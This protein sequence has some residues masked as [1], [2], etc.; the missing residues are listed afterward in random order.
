VG[1]VIALAPPDLAGILDPLDLPGRL[2][3]LALTA[4]NQEVF[5]SRWLAAAADG[6]GPAV[7]HPCI[8]TEVDYQRT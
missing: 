2:P 3:P 8:F 4:P 1:A 6:F 5:D 7:A